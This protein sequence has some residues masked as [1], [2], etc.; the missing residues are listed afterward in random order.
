MVD[1]PRMA[2]TPATNLTVAAGDVAVLQCEVTS[3]VTPRVKVSATSMSTSTNP[4]SSAH[5][6]PLAEFLSSQPMIVQPYPE[7]ST[8]PSGSMAAFQCRVW[9][10]SQPHLQ[11]PSPRHACDVTAS[12]L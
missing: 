11:V 9:S 8:L 2:D 1:A 12:R 10:D 6:P 7:N 5:S 3:L 4:G